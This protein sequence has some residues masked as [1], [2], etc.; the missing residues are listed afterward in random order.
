MGGLLDGQDGLLMSS[1]TAL[2][3]VQLLPFSIHYSQD[4]VS[5]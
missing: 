3:P 4:A 5:E 1:G 2:P